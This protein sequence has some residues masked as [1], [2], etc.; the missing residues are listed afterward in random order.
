MKRTFMITGFVLAMV[1]VCAGCRKTEPEETGSLETESSTAA[2]T[3]SE[4]NGAGRTSEAVSETALAET[5]EESTF[6]A[7]AEPVYIPMVVEQLSRVFETEA[8]EENISE[9]YCFYLVDGR[10]LLERH[11]YMDGSF[12]TYDAAEV[13]PK[14]PEYLFAEEEGTGSFEADFRWFSGFSMAGSY[15]FP[16]E[17][18]GIEVS[19]DTL[20]L[21]FES[22][23]TVIAQRKGNLR[24]LHPQG[25]F[26]ED[27]VPGA[28]RDQSGRMTGTWRES[29]TDADSRAVDTAACFGANDEFTLLRKTEGEPV[30][31][32][33]GSYAFT[34]DSTLAVLTQRFGYGEMPCDGSLAFSPDGNVL[35]LTDTDGTFLEAG[36]EIRLER[37]TVNPIHLGMK[38]KDDPAASYPDSVDLLTVYS[39]DNVFEAD[40]NVAILARVPDREEEYLF[41][42]DEETEFD[43]EGDLGSFEDL[44]EEETPLS[45]YRRMLLRE[46]EDLMAVVGVFGVQTTGQH[47][48]TL[49]GCYWWD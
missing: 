11:W 2:V 38:E 6:A 10:L 25:D 18:A 49:R 33:F 37:V 43:P 30:Q 5:E 23:D 15:R 28:K 35:T 17:H 24:G 36:E 13:F 21:T 27:T 39:A 20:T 12:Y 34:D 26:P 29:H 48:D 7:P 45:W 44:R 1:L 41:Y 14:E 42:V 8:D 4:N 47:I 32:F 40:G 19:E 16:E 3:V 9:A 46:E 31:V 22:G